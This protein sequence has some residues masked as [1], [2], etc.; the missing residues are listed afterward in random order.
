MNTNTKLNLMTPPAAPRRPIFRTLLV[1]F[2]LIVVSLVTY[3]QDATVWVGAWTTDWSSSTG[4]YSGPLTI[5]SVDSSGHATGTFVGGDGGTGSID[6]NV[7]FSLGHGWLLQGTWKRDAV[8]GRSSGGPCQNGR[9][10]LTIETAAGI[11]N[12]FTG[13][14]SYCNDD[15][16]GH[17]WLWEGTKKGST[18][19]G[20]SSAVW[21]IT[22]GLQTFY[23][24]FD[25]GQFRQMQGP[26]LTQV[27]IGETVWGLTSQ[28]IYRFNPGT[29]VFEKV[30]GPVLAQLAV[31][32]ASN[33]WGLT[34]A[35]QIF[36]LDP[37]GQAFQ[38][39]Q[40]P[41]LTQL[42]V[43]GQEIW[44]LAAQRAYHFNIHTPQFEE[45]Q[46]PPLTQLAVG[47]NDNV[48][49]LTP[50]HEVYQFNINTRVF[51]QVQGPALVQLSVGANAVWGLT[52]DQLIYSF[53]PNTRAFG[54]VQGPLFTHLTVG[55]T[56]IWGITATGQVY[57]YDFRAQAFK[58]LPGPTLMQLVDGSWWG[59][60]GC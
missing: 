48:W 10:S 47:A 2:W 37:N 57:R 5:K 4:K 24:D 46:G 11:T 20:L 13:Q 52:A 25:T 42:A 34:P 16:F 35:H 9:M 32:A 59:C 27:A 53:N 22:P 39:V 7:T 51:E 56:N 15:P 18:S 30:A 50:A 6:G 29:N 58:P 12:R 45:M 41:P 28:E 8:G 38:L 60:P 49:G 40:G 3:A 31:G 19:S 17:G 1:P 23:F 43:V 33:V 36:R 55:G 44:G 21:G 26:L 54:Q 14:W